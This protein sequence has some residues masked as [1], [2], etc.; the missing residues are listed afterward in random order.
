MIYFLEES[1]AK[2]YKAKD[3]KGAV[4]EYSVGIKA[5]PDLEE[6]TVPQ[7]AREAC[8]GSCTAGQNQVCAGE[9]GQDLL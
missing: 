4:R 3:W 2:L 9:L 8:A 7:D 5:C 6:Q 1:I